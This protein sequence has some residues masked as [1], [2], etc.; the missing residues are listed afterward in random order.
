MTILNERIHDHFV[1]TTSSFLA[2]RKIVSNGALL[3]TGSQMEAGAQSQSLGGGGSGQSQ[4][5]V[6]RV[7]IPEQ[8]IFF[9]KPSHLAKEKES[10]SEIPMQIRLVFYRKSVS[11]L[12]LNC[13]TCGGNSAVHPSLQSR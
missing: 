8:R 10:L 2:E 5:Q 9:S 11:Y 3:L 13:W 6:R 1:I 12:L 7:R 4:E